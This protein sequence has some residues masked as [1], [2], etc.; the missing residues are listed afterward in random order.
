MCSNRVFVNSRHHCSLCAY[1][2]RS[3]TTGRLKEQVQ[4]ADIYCRLLQ[5]KK[6]QEIVANSTE[7]MKHQKEV[8]AATTLAMIVGTF[9]VLWMPGIISLFLMA[10][11]RN[12]DFHID[13]L[14]LSTILVHLNS[15]IDPIIYAY[16]MRKIREAL[17][18][19]FKCFKKSNRI[20]NQS[21]S[22]SNETRTNRTSIKTSAS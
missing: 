9:I 15:A 3:V 1:L 14:E 7:L 6:R 11:T 19:F 18:Q 21:S 12:R 20:G 13:I 8:R 10:I 16:R 22:S 5:A 17:N 4:F 2:S